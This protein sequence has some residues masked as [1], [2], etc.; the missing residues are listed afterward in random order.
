VNAPRLVASDV[1]GTL[2]DPSDR[3]SERTR[4]AV[5]RV[6]AAGVPFVLVTGRPPRWI[7]PVVELLGH[8]GLTVCANGS[9][10]Y[11]AATGKVGHIVTIDPIQL[12]DAAD[13]VATALPGAKLAV[14][15]L[16]GEEL[17]GA[18]TNGADQFLAEPG[19][20]HPWPGDDSRIVS[21]DLILGRPATKLLVRQPGASSDEMA[22][23]VRELLDVQSGL[24]LDVTYSTGYGLI[25]LS[26]PG[27]TKGTGLARLAKE[28]G[29]APGDV[30]AIGD[31]PND[32]SMLQWAGHG[33]AMANAHPTVLEAADEI[34]AGNSEDGLAV[35][36]ERWF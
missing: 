18:A 8:A 15:L 9:V 17:I 25:E 27:I 29:I 12:R 5:H 2:L 32:L 3:I 19:Y 28:L 23:A 26:A 31:M 24:S 1:D 7:R 11:D 6:V 30:L 35:I 20:T 22:A 13:V 10:L 4:A 36:L 14:E 16:L 33:V 34:T 21:R